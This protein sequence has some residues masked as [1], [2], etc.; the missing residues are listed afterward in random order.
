MLALLPG[1]GRGASNTRKGWAGKSAGA[2][3]CQC[4][5]VSPSSRVSLRT[6]HPGLDPQSQSPVFRGLPCQDRIRQPLSTELQ[7]GQTHSAVPEGGEQAGSQYAREAE[8]RRDHKET[9]TRLPILRSVPLAEN[10]PWGAV[11][12]QKPQG[13]ESAPNPSQSYSDRHH[14]AHLSETRDQVSLNPGALC[15]GLHDGAR[16]G[17]QRA[18]LVTPD[19]CFFSLPGPERRVP[20]PLLLTSP[21]AGRRDR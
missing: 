6:S 18:L 10:T 11:V 9:P 13:T 17:G 12:T 20:D 7:V 5:Q 8:Q 16:A 1:L 2:I 14:S 3:S 15:W 19:F 21:S 4:K